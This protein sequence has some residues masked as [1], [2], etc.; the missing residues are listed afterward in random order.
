MNGTNSEGHMII[1]YRL[2]L[3]DRNI[4]LCRNSQKYEPQ[5]TQLTHAI[6]SNIDFLRQ[7]TLMA[8]EKV[9]SDEQ[10][11]GTPCNLIPAFRV[12]YYQT[13]TSCAQG[14]TLNS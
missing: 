13:V 8:R 5:E 2:D 14:E 12:C 11:T 3:F 10:V 1:S 4:A 9:M 7:C 6:S